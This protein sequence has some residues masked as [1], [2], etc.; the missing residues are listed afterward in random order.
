MTGPNLSA[1]TDTGITVSENKNMTQATD[2]NFIRF[3]NTPWNS[4]LLLLIL[5]KP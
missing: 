5:F 4:L 2:K 3:I 1:D